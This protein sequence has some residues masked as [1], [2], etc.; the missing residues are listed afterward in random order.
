MG[1][2]ALGQSSEIGA[3]PGQSAAALPAPPPLSPRYPSDAGFLLPPRPLF[4]EIQSTELRLVLRISDRRV[5]VY[6]GDKVEVSYPVAVGK[7]GWET[8]TGSHEVIAMIENPSWENPFTGDV[9]PAGPDNPLGERWIGF[10]TDG[11]NFVGFHGTPNEGS[12]GRAASHGCVRMYNSDIRELFTVV[13]MG[14][15]VVV[16]P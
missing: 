4:P 10:W 6:R 14:T 1:Q 9:I 8:P 11:R 12:V 16:E 3:A 7:A 2:P 15:P 5:Y 13:A